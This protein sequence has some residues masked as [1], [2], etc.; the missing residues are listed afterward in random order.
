MH[1]PTVVT[2]G[3]TADHGVLA[4]ARLGTCRFGLGT[5]SPNAECRSRSAGRRAGDRRHGRRRSA[6]RHNFGDSQPRAT[7]PDRPVPAPGLHPVTSSSARR[8]RTGRRDE[9]RLDDWV[10]SVLDGIYARTSS[11]TTAR[12]PTR[13]IWTRRSA[14]AQAATRPS[15]GVGR[16]PYDEKQGAW[17]LKVRGGAASIRSWRSRA[18]EWAVP[19]QEDEDDEDKT[20][21]TNNAPSEKDPRQSADP[22]P[23]RPTTTALHLPRRRCTPAG[24]AIKACSRA[25]R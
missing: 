18:R 16:R 6:R 1:A 23:R 14:D 19:T 17:S 24:A 3:F 8:W 13:S 15:I 21:P 4:P 2:A 20:V 22:R 5:A 11:I 10:P 9:R 12:T 7:A 25:T